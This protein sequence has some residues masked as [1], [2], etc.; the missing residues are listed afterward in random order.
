MLAR[1]MTN[2]WKQAIEVSSGVIRS[3]TITIYITI[4]IYTCLSIYALLKYYTT[5]ML[6][7]S[8]YIYM[9]IYMYTY[10]GWNVKLSKGCLKVV[11]IFG[12]DAQDVTKSWTYHEN[13]INKNARDKMLARV[14]TNMW[15]QSTN[16]GVWSVYIPSLNIYIYIYILSLSIYT[17]SWSIYIYILDSNLIRER[18]FEGRAEMCGGCARRDNIVDVTR[19][20][21]ARDTMLARVVIN[22]W[23]QAIEV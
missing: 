11:H 22:M 15:K 9:Y 20:T 13:I 12:A 14:V 10:T 16:I 7:L 1:D 6:C 17:L 4:Y 2:M 5:Y 21:N 23:K 3:Q 18:F 19:E 8:I